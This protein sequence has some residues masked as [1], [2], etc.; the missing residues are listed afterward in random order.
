MHDTSKDQ[1]IGS[2]VALS[3]GGV[4][5]AAAMAV[6]WPAATVSEP[7]RWKR[8]PKHLWGRLDAISRCPE[9]EYTGIG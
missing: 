2:L 4:L 9:L 6:H 5:V 3:F 8:Q 7:W 1:I